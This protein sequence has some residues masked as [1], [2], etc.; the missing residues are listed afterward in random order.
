MQIYIFGDICDINKT[1]IECAILIKVK[2][3]KA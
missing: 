2:V 1:V 3:L